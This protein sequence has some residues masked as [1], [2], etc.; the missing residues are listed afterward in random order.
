MYILFRL[1]AII[2]YSSKLGFVE[3]VDICKL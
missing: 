3:D 1:Y 2:A